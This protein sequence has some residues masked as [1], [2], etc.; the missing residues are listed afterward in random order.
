MSNLSAFLAQNAIKVEIEKYVASKRFLNEEGK[1]MEWEIGGINSEED[2][3]LRKSCTK[4]VPVPGKRNAFIPETDFNT[5]V[6]KQ[7]VKC[8]LFPNLNDKELQDSYGVMSGEALLKVMLTPGE[9]ADYIS[10]VQE[11][12]GF[13]RPLEDA[14]EEAKN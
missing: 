5:Y 14:V 8:T 13:N 11:V 2:E 7:A 6:T 1:P 12:N 3:L 10:K 4:R 9:Y